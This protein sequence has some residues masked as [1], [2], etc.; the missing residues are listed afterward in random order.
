MRE[1]SGR[2]GADHQTS[3]RDHHFGAWASG[4]KDSYLLDFKFSFWLTPWKD[5]VNYILSPLLSFHLALSPPPFPTLKIHQKVDL[6]SPESPGSTGQRVEMILGLWSP[7][8]F[9][10]S[11]SHFPFALRFFKHRVSLGT[12]IVLSPHPSFCL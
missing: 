7:I 9:N 10:V 6:P 2:E 4:F 8:L 11:L 1:I 3:K 5:N 12:A